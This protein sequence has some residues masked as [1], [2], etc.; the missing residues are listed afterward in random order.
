MLFFLSSAN[1][2]SVDAGA[3]SKDATISQPM[4]P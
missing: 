4:K 1:S 2:N 3:Q